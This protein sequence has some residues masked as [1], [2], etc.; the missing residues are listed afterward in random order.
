[1]TKKAF[2]IAVE[3][4]YP[5]INFTVDTLNGQFVAVCSRSGVPFAKVNDNKVVPF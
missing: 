3:Q 4:Q 5:C 1:M 2:R